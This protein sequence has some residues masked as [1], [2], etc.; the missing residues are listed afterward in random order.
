MLK[1]IPSIGGR[2][3]TQATSLDPSPMFLHLCW[4]DR[5]L[6]SWL[7]VLW[8]CPSLL[9]CFDVFLGF[10]QVLCS[11]CLEMLVGLA[12]RPQAVKEGSGL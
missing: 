8:P 10:S 2:L 12:C 4:A 1:V 7:A 5:K 11:F 6:H 9:G 3:G